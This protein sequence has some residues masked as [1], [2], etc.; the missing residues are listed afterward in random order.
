M[1]S[2]ARD[3]GRLV[4]DERSDMDRENAVSYNFW[5]R[6]RAGASCNACR[7]TGEAGRRHRGRSLGRERAAGP[8]A[9]PR[10]LSCGCKDDEPPKPSCPLAKPQQNRPR[11]PCTLGFATCQEDEDDDEENDDDEDDDQQ[12]TDCSCC[13]DREDEGL[14]RPMGKEPFTPERHRL[15]VL[16]K[17]TRQQQALLM[18]DEQ[19]WRKGRRSSG[20][21]PPLPA[22]KECC[23]PPPAKVECCPRPPA[24]KECCPPPPAKM[25]SC[26]PPPAKTD[27][28]SPPQPKKGC[29]TPP[30]S[31]KECCPS[32]PVKKD[33]CRSSRKPSTAQSPVSGG[34]GCPPPPPRQM[35]E[36]TSCC[37]CADKVD[38]CGKLETAKNDCESGSC[39]KKQSCSDPLDKCFNGSR[40]TLGQYLTQRAKDM[41]GCGKDK[42]PADEAPK[43]CGRK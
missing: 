27:S 6:V 38:E 24:K 16:R 29:C 18:D 3:G 9:G 23:L 43:S 41:C 13:S 4:D 17:I 10:R 20:C 8:S 11:R 12:Q 31:K 2:V 15:D 22:K 28:C 14:A 34:C 36:N 35:S 40:D 32:T 39:E 42:G 5:R 25:D 1:R 37:G 30:P 33:C 26:P 7:T 21:G 19:R